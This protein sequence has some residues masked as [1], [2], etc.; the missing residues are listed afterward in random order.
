M[1]AAPVIRT[2]CGS[3]DWDSPDWGG[4]KVLLEGIR[5]HSKERTRISDQRTIAVLVYS[6][7][8]GGVI[9]GLWGHSSFGVLV[10]NLFFLPA[11]LRGRGLGRDLLARAEAEAVRQ[12]CRSCWLE[13]MEFQAP[14]FYARNGYE[15]F[16]RIDCAPPGNARIF[17]RKPLAA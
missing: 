7:S 11:E 14:G 5:G 15:E 10:I 2:L 8:D 13:T 1:D 17:M 12:G 3:L 4:F 6:P 16:G 9:G